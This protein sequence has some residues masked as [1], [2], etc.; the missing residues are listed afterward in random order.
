MCFSGFSRRHKN[1]NWRQTLFAHLHTNGGINSNTCVSFFF[2][3][4]HLF[5]HPT[6]AVASL[7]KASGKNLHL[8]SRCI[9]FKSHVYGRFNTSA[10]NTDTHT[11]RVLS[12]V[13]SKLP[14][15]IQAIRSGND[16]LLWTMRHQS[17]RAGSRDFVL[18]FFTLFFISL[19]MKLAPDHREAVSAARQLNPGSPLLQR[20][21]ISPYTTD[22]R[23]DCDCFWICATSLQRVEVR[24]SHHPPP[25]QPHPLPDA[26]QGTCWRCSLAV[27]LGCN[28]RFSPC[29]RL[30]LSTKNAPT[31][32]PAL[33]FSFCTWQTWCL[34]SM[35]RVWAQ[36]T[37]GPNH[38]SSCSS[39]W[40]I[41]FYHFKT[42]RD[43]APFFK[44][45]FSKMSYL[46]LVLIWFASV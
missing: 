26:V 6:S 39:K 22:C 46:I 27:W 17:C 18:F 2:I 33:S 34:R 13:Q 45:L 44:D 20:C 25:P 35:R 4:Y 30:L 37:C 14:L 5:F 36:K 38:S 40:I 9:T 15:C 21:D 10:N 11:R 8:L 29:R 23:N 7:F 16:R 24:W 28:Q 1:T 32:T 42:Y 43:W 41:Q 3:S 19:N 12:L 31:I